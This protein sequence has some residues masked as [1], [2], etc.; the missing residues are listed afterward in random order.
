MA[1]LRCY[2]YFN[3]TMHAEPL[4]EDDW[5]VRVNSR[6]WNLSEAIA[7]TDRVQVDCDS[8]GAF[9]GGPDRVRYLNLRG[10][11]RDVEGLEVAA[12]FHPI[13]RTD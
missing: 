11:L 4:F 7:R 6:I 8:P 1:V 9:Q 2:V 13:T 3:K 5:E 10:E 12:F